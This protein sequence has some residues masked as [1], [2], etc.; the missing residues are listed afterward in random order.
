VKTISAVAIIAASILS[1]VMAHAADLPPTWGAVTANGVI[2]TKMPDTLATGD[3]FSSGRA[4]G[5]EGATA[6]TSSPAPS[7]PQISTT[8]RILTRTQISTTR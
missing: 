1:S 8:M 4:T 6:R 7:T 5:R 3:F 2:K